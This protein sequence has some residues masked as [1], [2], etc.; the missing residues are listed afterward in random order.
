MNFAPAVLTIALLAQAGAPAA[1]P[2]DEVR[3]RVRAL[4]LSID[5]PISPAAIRAVGPGAD[6]ALAE[7]ALSRDFPVRR[8]RALEALASLA[9]PRAEEVHRSAAASG[10]P[11]TVRRAA[12][13]GL[14]SL[15][16]ADRAPEELRPFVERDRDPAIRAAA[17][18]ALARAAPAAGCAIVRAQA[19]R[20]D[21]TDRARFRRALSA[22]ASW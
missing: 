1:A 15:V 17:A 4:L 7:I 18:E 6:E 8:A 12:V 13:L 16:P 3:E 19:G 10:E 11:R 21:A 20:E 9:S 22:C 2:S 14:A 5:R